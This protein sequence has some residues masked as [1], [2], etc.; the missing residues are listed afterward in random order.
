MTS[1]TG[2]A[3]RM[4]VGT[5]RH[6]GWRSACDGHM[7]VHDGRQTMVG[8]VSLTP[9][10]PARSLAP[11]PEAACESVIRQLEVVNG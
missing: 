6:A 11:A 2:H 8:T 4:W 10:H 5:R 1:A 7:V 9:S 3:A